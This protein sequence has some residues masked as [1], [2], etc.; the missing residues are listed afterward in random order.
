MKCNVC[1]TPVAEDENICLS[2]QSE[3]PDVFTCCECGKRGVT[4]DGDFGAWK[5]RSHTKIV[6]SE[7]VAQ[8]SQDDLKE[9]YYQE[10]SYME[11]FDQDD[12]W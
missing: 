2:C 12:K 9:Q 4:D 5:N 3:I 7:C 11:F 1:G 6:C 10:E 8:E